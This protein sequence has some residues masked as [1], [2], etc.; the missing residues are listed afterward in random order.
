[1]KLFLFCLGAA[2]AAL[3]L[4]SCE[5]FTS[6]EATATAT[7]AVAQTLTQA[8]AA[9]VVAGV[10]DQAQFLEVTAALTAAAEAT[11]AAARE[12]GYTF[13]WTKLAELAGTAMVAVTGTN[14]LR[15]RA[16]RSRGEVTGTSVAAIPGTLTTP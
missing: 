13:D 1:M 6:P 16:R 7:A 11:N 14:L 5:I 10:L 2:L 3:C 4:S 12:T 15:N 9:M 8:L